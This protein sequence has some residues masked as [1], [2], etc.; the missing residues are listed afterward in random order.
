[1]VKIS[2]EIR[3]IENGFIYE[4]SYYDDEIFCK[5]FDKACSLVNKNLQKFREDEVEERS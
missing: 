1:M 2:I 5:D 3:K 4:D